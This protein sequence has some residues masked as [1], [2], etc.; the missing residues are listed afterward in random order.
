[1]APRK[2]KSNSKSK[3]PLYSYFLYNIYV[4]YGLFF[5]AILNVLKLL[6]YNQLKAISVFFITGSLF[7]FFTRN[8]IVIMGASIVASYIFCMSESILK[9]RP[10]SSSSIQ[11]YS[12]SLWGSVYEGMDNEADAEADAEDDADDDADAEKEDEPLQEGARGC[13]GDSCGKIRPKA[14][15]DEDAVDDT[16]VDKASTI[17]NSYSQ[18]SNLLG[19]DNMK[20]LSNETAK[21]VKQQQQLIETMKGAGPV[22]DNMKSMLNGL[23]S[24]D[25]MSMQNNM[26]GL[27]SQMNEK[28]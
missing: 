19:E 21:L 3:L 18:L 5:L 9:S 27:I 17:E 28:K 23:N 11:G 2:S 4:L 24:K 10:S 12:G 16:Y 22:M 15:Q 8:M 1:M 20:N 14:L 6:H 26:S 13:K 7:S 25:M